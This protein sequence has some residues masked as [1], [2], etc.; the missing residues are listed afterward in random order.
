MP[1]PARRIGFQILLRTETE[2][3]FAADLLHSPLTDGLSERDAALCTQLVLGT[4]RWR[5]TLDFIAQQ[6][7]R[8]PT[9]ELDPPVR[10]ALWMGLYQ[11]RYLDRVPPHAAVHETVELVKQAGKAS[12]AGLVNAVLR[13]GEKLELS[14]LRPAGMTDIAWQAV[15]ASFPEWLLERWTRRLGGREALILAR[16]SNQSP[17]TS[18]RMREG[19]IPSEKLIDA[20]RG[21]GIDAVSGH[22]LKTSL[23]LK[24]G[25]L[26][27]SPAFL[28]AGCVIQ[29]EASQLVP[30]LIGVQPNVQSDAQHNAQI[31][32]DLCAAPG[33]KTGLLAAWAGPQG[34][35]IAC[36][37]H[38]HRLRQLLS[39]APNI[40]RVVL[41]GTRSLPFRAVFDRILLDVP[42][43]GT[44]TLRRN[45]ELKWRLR[46]ADIHAMPEKQQMF[47][48]QASEVLKPGGRI[49]YSTCS[50]EPEENQ[51]VVEAFLG[52]RPDFRLVPVRSEIA[53]LDR[54]LQPAGRDLL[55]AEY[56]TTSPVAGSSTGLVAG[57][58][59]GSTDGFFAA[60]LERA[61]DG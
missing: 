2:S 33:N 20:L 53:R 24:E 32:L 13:K 55:E 38:P 19:D 46:R 15:E 29:D 61:G 54:V 35:V 44:G 4:L 3:S 57:P 9:A 11:L 14:T 60:I 6:L 21:E 45:P 37:I 16:A 10:V 50:L 42:C 59:T 7:T 48:Q 27:R 56:L 36:D 52:S 43:T 30:H 47:L 39:A 40:R 31:V 58:D 41:D 23:T 12:A 8:K 51:Q 5:G 26:N 18:F 22:L 34:S 17:S 25:N 1:S 49:V 28:Q